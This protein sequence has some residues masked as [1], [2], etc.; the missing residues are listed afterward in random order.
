MRSGFSQRLFI[1]KLKQRVMNKIS[2][3]S[4]W[5]CTHAHAHRHHTCALM[6]TCSHP[7]WEDKQHRVTVRF[8][9]SQKGQSLHHWR[10]QAW[11]ADSR[12]GRVQG[13]L[14]GNSR[15]APR[16]SPSMLVPHCSRTTAKLSPQRTVT[17]LG[18]VLR[19][20][21]SQ[22]VSFYPLSNSQT[23]VVSSWS[24]SLSLLLSLPPPP[25]RIS[26]QHH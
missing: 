13:A 12:E 15:A 21:I 2:T 3:V 19:R 7:A 25:L 22:S 6:L 23:K 24:P 10:P 26:Y 14:P 20:H 8:L 18:T 16:L 5:L 1:Q 11:P 9:C 17:S 4:L